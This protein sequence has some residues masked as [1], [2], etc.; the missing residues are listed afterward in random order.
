[1]GGGLGQLDVLDS[2]YAVDLRNHR[3]PELYRELTNPKVR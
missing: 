3:R 1:V 2:G